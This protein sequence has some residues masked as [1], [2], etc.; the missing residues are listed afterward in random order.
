[1]QMM[2]LSIAMGRSKPV[3]KRLVRHS[4]E[5]LNSESWIDQYVGMTCLGA[6]ISGPDQNVIYTQMDNSYQSIM[7][8]FN[9]CQ[10]SRVRYATGW[11]INNLVSSLPSLI[12]KSQ[13]NLD[14]FVNTAIT[15]LDSQIEH[16]TIKGFM[17]QCF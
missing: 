2:L 8:L 11:V 12:F 10:Y 6:I 16:H 15:H 17:A 13:E 5:K 7:N 9:N 14:L 4:M 3:S 1:M